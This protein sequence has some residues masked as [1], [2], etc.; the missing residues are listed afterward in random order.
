M[1]AFA[2]A[3]LLKPVLA[4]DALHELAVAID[5]ESGS[6]LRVSFRKGH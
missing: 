2:A 4:Q 5:H 3:E 1:I 6:D